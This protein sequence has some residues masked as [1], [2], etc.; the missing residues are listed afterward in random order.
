MA[1]VKTPVAPSKR[2]KRRRK[3]KEKIL[4]RSSKPAGMSLEEWQTI[5]RR[6]F[7]REQKYKL[8]NIGDDAVFSE[9]RVTNPQSKS[10]YRVVIRGSHDG[11]NHCQCADFATN[12][13]GTCKHIEFVLA[14]LQRT[15]RTAVGIQAAVQRDRVEIRGA[16]GSAL[17]S[18]PGHSTGTARSR[19]QIL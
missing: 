1:A 15:D 19:Q 11:D 3:S 7:G 10:T 6:Q 17:S 5:L 18:G 4:S 9:F 16:A 12:T 2:T 13:L 14:K 8:E